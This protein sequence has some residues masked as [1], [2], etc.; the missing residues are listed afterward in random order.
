MSEL[1]C[2]H[3]GKP[4]SA[5]DASCPHCGMPLPPAGTLT[6]H[7]KFVYWFIALAVFCLLLIY[8][9]PPDWTGL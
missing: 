8:W 5:Q 2:H 3:C 6:A 7:R 4:V 1:K 9:L